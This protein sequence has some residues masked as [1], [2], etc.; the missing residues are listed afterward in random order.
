VFPFIHFFAPE[1]K[2][3]LIRRFTHILINFQAIEYE[4]GT[5]ATQSQLAKDVA[6]FL[7]WAASPEQDVR[8]KIFIKVNFTHVTVVAFVV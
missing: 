2:Y 7:V 5:P 1:V 8:K 6:T 4:D 3:F